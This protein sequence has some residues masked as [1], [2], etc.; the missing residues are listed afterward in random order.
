MPGAKKKKKKAMRQPQRE[1][2]LEVYEELTRVSFLESGNRQYVRKWVL[3][4]DC[5][6][7]FY[8]SQEDVAFGKDADNMMAVD[9]RGSLCEQHRS[10]ERTFSL[11]S[12]ALYTIHGHKHKMLIRTAADEDVQPWVSD[13]NESA[14]W[15][16]VLR[17]AASA[18]PKKSA[19]RRVG[20]GDT[21]DDDLQSVS[22][23]RTGLSE[24]G[25]RSSTT[26]RAA[27]SETQGLHASQASPG[28][29]LGG[30]LARS[31][32]SLTRTNNTTERKKDQRG[33]WLDSAPGRS[34]RN[35]LGALPEQ[36]LDD[37]IAAC[38][39]LDDN[40]SRMAHQVSAQ[41]GSRRPDALPPGQGKTM[42]KAQGRC[43]H[44]AEAAVDESAGHSPSV[45]DAQMTSC[46]G[47]LQAL[48]QP[49][50]SSVKGAESVLLKGVM[51]GTSNSGSGGS[52]PWLVQSA[53]PHLRSPSQCLSSSPS[54]RA[55]LVP[56]P[57]APTASEAIAEQEEA[58]AVLEM[59]RHAMRQRKMM[60]EV[61]PLVLAHSKPADGG[62]ERLRASS[63]ASSMHTKTDDHDVASVGKRA[64]DLPVSGAQEPKADLVDT[65]GVLACARSDTGFS[66]LDD[67]VTQ[68]TES[69]AS[70]CRDSGAGSS[71]DESED[72]AIEARRREF[73][74]SAYCV[75]ASDSEDDLT[76]LDLRPQ[77][78]DDFERQLVRVRRLRRVS[79]RKA[80]VAGMVHSWGSGF[81]YCLGHGSHVDEKYPRI[82]RSLS[83]KGIVQL[84]A[85]GQH[86]AALSSC[87]EIFT[88][89]VGLYGRLGHDSM[90]DCPWPTLIK[91]TRKGSQ[92]AQ[93]ACGHMHSAFVTSEGEVWCWGMGLYGQ[94]G[95]G[96]RFDLWLPTQVNDLVGVVVTHVACGHH[97][98]LAS[99]GAGACYA[100]GRGRYG[101]LGLG[102]LQDCLKPQR[103]EGLS[104]V[105]VVKL[106]AGNC[107]PLA[108]SDDGKL[109][110]WGRG[111][112]GTHGLG[113]T[114]DVL[115]P[116]VMGLP[117]DR[118]VVDMDCGRHHCALLTI[119]G[120]VWCWGS[121]QGYSL[122][123]GNEKDSMTPV[124]VDSIRKFVIVQ[125]SCG[126]NR[127]AAV[128]RGGNLYMWGGGTAVSDPHR[129]SDLSNHFGKLHV[130][131]EGGVLD[132]RPPAG[133][134]EHFSLSMG[135][136]DLFPDAQPDKLPADLLKAAFNEGIPPNQLLRLRFEL[137]DAAKCAVASFGLS[138]GLLR[139]A[140]AVHPDWGLAD[141]DHDSGGSTDPTADMYRSAQCES[142]MIAKSSIIA[143]LQ[144][145]L[146]VL[147]SRHVDTREAM[148]LEHGV[149]RDVLRVCL[150]AA[151]SHSRPHFTDGPPPRPHTY[152]HH[153]SVYACSTAQAQ[154]GGV[155][156]E[157]QARGG[158]S[159]PEGFDLS[160]A[161]DRTQATLFGAREAS[162]STVSGRS[163]VPSRGVAV[164]RSLVA[165]QT[166]GR[167]PAPVA[168]VPDDSSEIERAGCVG[169]GHLSYAE[170]DNVWSDSD[171]DDSSQALS[172][173]SDPSLSKVPAA[174][175]S[176]GQ[177]RKL[178]QES[179]ASVLRKSL[180]R[181]RLLRQLLEEVVLIVLGDG[182]SL[183]LCNKKEAASG[184][185]AAQEIR[186]DSKMRQRSRL[187]Q[188][189]F[190]AR[191]TVQQPQPELP[192]HAKV[193][194]DAAG[195]DGRRTG[196]QDSIA[197]R[198]GKKSK[199]VTGQQKN[200]EHEMGQ[201][202][203]PILGS[204]PMTQRSE[205]T[206][207]ERGKCDDRNDRLNHCCEC[208]STGCLACCPETAVSPCEGQ[209]AAGVGE[210]EGCTTSHTT[211]SLSSGPSSVSQGGHD[212]S[213]NVEGERGATRKKRKKKTSG[214]QLKRVQE[215]AA[216]AGNEEQ[217]Q[218]TVQGWMLVY[219]IMIE[220]RLPQYIARH[221]EEP[222]MEWQKRWA[223]LNYNQ[224]LLFESPADAQPVAT[225]VL[226]GYFIS[227][228]THETHWDMGNGMASRKK[229]P[230]EG[231][232][233]TLELKPNMLSSTGANN[234]RH[235]YC[236]TKD[237]DQLRVWID[238]LREAAI[239]MLVR[240]S[241]VPAQRRPWD[242]DVDWSVPDAMAAWD[243]WRSPE[244]KLHSTENFQ[245]HAS[246]AM[247]I[248]S[249]QHDDSLHGED[250]RLAAADGRQ[251]SANKGRAGSRIAE[252]MAGVVAGLTPPWSSTPRS[253]AS[254]ATA[255]ASRA[256]SGSV[257]ATASDS[258]VAAAVTKERA[259]A[260]GS[261]SFPHMPELPVSRTFFP[262]L[263]GTHME[264]MSRV[265]DETRKQLRMLKE[266]HRE[267]LQAHALEAATWAFEK[268]QLHQALHQR[269]LELSKATT[270][271][272][273]MCYERD[274]ARAA[275]RP[276]FASP[277]L[278]DSAQHGPRMADAP[279][280]D[281]TQDS[282]EFKPSVAAHMPSSALPMS[283]KHPVEVSSTVI[284]VGTGPGGLDEGASGSTH[285]R[286]RFGATSLEIAP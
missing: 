54:V 278:A 153:D 190:D 128:A 126:G 260:G 239:L 51:S 121:G 155:E 80:A 11:E 272:A 224:L 143:R 76:D 199:T 107:N 6:L 279:E 108:L 209:S 229:G 122:G 22:S 171:Q 83:S 101:C 262:A 93:V 42:A 96:N 136:L 176:Q 50:F 133:F 102:N 98:T 49:V 63:L 69:Q 32:S 18:G 158:M 201:N 217:E 116:H 120:E 270:E 147:E 255:E 127:T 68:Y 164:P 56:Q 237:F 192:K 222:A 198:K 44:D 9:L 284:V 206:E 231:N 177:G 189:A 202:S 29:S 175:A 165:Y 91:T 230:G 149:A 70:S 72:Q 55:S 111:R 271:M 256:G 89:G 110:S 186:V 283:P 19:H 131:E 124:R 174:E 156:D 105:H 196:E 23:N 185:W 219:E 3:L 251:A 33:P 236:R 79:R 64:E 17:A 167:A 66:V 139:A 277:R 264:E 77:C 67:V 86:A 246:P 99:T 257:S 203:A 117:E 211:E 104:R 144:Q 233:P 259:A 273:T 240:N 140:P 275:T 238:A 244:E 145:A 21:E 134:F 193:T 242:A 280:S 162:S 169:D 1:G 148:S 27:A 60:T 106:V 53:A 7:Y 35:Q 180:A 261:N 170:P 118:I 226:D 81:N 95:Q 38:A 100:W 52:T 48:G 46:Q 168:D 179:D 129:F 37:S 39:G 142:G 59:S 221:F 85:G 223:I 207:T 57:P 181:P 97:Y 62:V 266:Q 252:M 31:W 157:L 74:R 82:L 172:G 26:S 245:L 151:P 285:E 216:L 243:E 75:R 87:G 154:S 30:S 132:P 112:F 263:V 166:E 8:D 249:S 47:K 146:S 195:A 103:L 2:W 191:Q 109:Y 208:N 188:R 73:F 276:A 163:G 114:S 58:G 159:L 16:M 269:T 125:V 138:R 267:S 265:L 220:V 20:Q 40:D 213:L 210:V 214:I 34:A 205:E 248:H 137:V 13:I 247:T 43:S 94:L 15:D 160:E 78:R 90:R 61:P 24:T 152:I 45:S 141:E 197:A 10:L 228:F 258:V 254:A 130:N 14:I 84:A 36:A 274:G 281:L 204:A 183:A 215:E 123:T 184:A 235:L 182:F 92:A 234:T 25:S 212:P 241:L 41:V 268:K 115:E 218:E 194:G 173:R 28:W 187:A 253:E 119:K 88:W 4:R 178:A 135:S 113:H 200:A 227:D 5:W 286:N 12:S 65:D 232:I 250:A 225:V 282:D 161:L 150:E 71:G